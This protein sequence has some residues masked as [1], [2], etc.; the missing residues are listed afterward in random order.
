MTHGG[1][2]GYGGTWGWLSGVGGVWGHLGAYYVA[3]QVG[4]VGH[5]GGVLGC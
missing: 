1:C 4:G 5:H 2:F 3:Q